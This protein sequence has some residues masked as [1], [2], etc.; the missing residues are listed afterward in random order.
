MNFKTV[1][2]I[3]AVGI[4]LSGCATIIKG[5]TQ[6]IVITS[7]PVTGASCTLSS[8]EGNWPVVT[9]GSVTVDKTKEDILIKCTKAGYQDG[10]GT[11]PSD[12][13]GWTLGNLILGGIIGVGVD[14]STGAM[15]EYPNAFAVPMT[16]LPTAAPMPSLPATQP[17]PG[18]PPTTPSG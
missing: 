18:A 12:F 16:P 6:T 2:V 15:N 8:K 9:P 17:A 13:Q 5:T 4:A 1:A 10:V 3:T 14:A 7:P 11:I